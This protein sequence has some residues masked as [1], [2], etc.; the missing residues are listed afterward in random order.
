LV[1]GSEPGLNPR[2]DL[3]D[4]IAILEDRKG[5]VPDRDTDFDGDGSEDMRDL[6]LFSTEWYREPN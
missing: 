6:F 2:C 3:F 1:E 5:I 4:L